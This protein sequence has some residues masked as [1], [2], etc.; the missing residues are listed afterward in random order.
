MVESTAST[1]L[2]EE[3][4]SHWSWPSLSVVIEAGRTLS[5]WHTSCGSLV[6]SPP[7]HPSTISAAQTHAKQATVSTASHIQLQMSPLWAPALFDVTNN[8]DEFSFAQVS[9]NYI[10]YCLGLSHQA[11]R[12][13]SSGDYSCPSDKCMQFKPAH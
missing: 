2:R 4:I 12:S 3:T 9:E 10:V 8:E 6:S 1:S 5:L 13:V 11:V 7:H